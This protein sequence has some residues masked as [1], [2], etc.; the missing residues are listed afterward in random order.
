MTGRGGPDI[1]QVSVGRH[2]ASDLYESVQRWTFRYIAS[3]H[4]VVDFCQSLDRQLIVYCIKNGIV[5]AP[6]NRNNRQDLRL[7]G[8][9]S[10]RGIGDL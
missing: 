7:S 5:F 8:D 4:P 9:A 1:N 10:R 2:R 3:R 6:I